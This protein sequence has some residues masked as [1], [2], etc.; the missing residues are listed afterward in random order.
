MTAQ[1][2]AAGASLDRGV[3]ARDCDGCETVG[4]V[5]SCDSHD[6]ALPTPDGA[7]GSTFHTTEDEMTAING[8]KAPDPERDDK[9][10][11]RPKPAR[12]VWFTVRLGPAFWPTA[13]NLDPTPSEVA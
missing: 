13:S 7:L 5:P 10:T 3:G 1:D 11:E 12:G 6:L 8:T 9:L 4:R 2:T